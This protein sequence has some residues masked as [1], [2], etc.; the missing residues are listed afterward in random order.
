MNMNNLGIN[1]CIIILF[2]CIVIYVILN[3]NVYYTII[4]Q[5]HKISEINNN[6]IKNY[7]IPYILIEKNEFN[8]KHKLNTLLKSITYPK[9]FKP[10]S[11]SGCNNKVELI[12]SFEEALHYVNTI[13]S[14]IFLPIIIQD[15]IRGK[16]YS[17]LYKRYPLSGKHEI[18]V[19]EKQNQNCFFVDLNT[20]KK[21][22][23]NVYRRTDLET[24]KLKK[25]IVDISEKISP[26]ITWCRYDMLLKDET[27]EL[28]KNGDDINIIEINLSF[29]TR[30][31]RAIIGTSS[32]INGE[33]KY[34]YLSFILFI[35]EILYKIY[36]SIMN[37]L[38]FNGITS[39]HLSYL[40]PD[41]FLKCLIYKDKM[42]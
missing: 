16:E 3:L 20:C 19:L 8:N 24:S 35:E 38:L 28:F 40:K 41:I 36:A 7:F 12:N 30:D 42:C 11:C 32:Y 23:R 17:I 10:S 27:E 6:V 14:S 21:Q 34:V 26:I 39:S 37:I 18:Y 22:V 9:V 5:K 33:K 29:S 13:K 25:K 2:L 15:Y 31:S 1:I 4:N